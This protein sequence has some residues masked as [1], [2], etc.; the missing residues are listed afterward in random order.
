MNVR[1]A[2]PA[3]INLTLRVGPARADGLHPLQSVVAFA[4][5]GE[6]LEAA[7]ADVL[8]LTIIGPFAADLEADESNLVMRAARA[9][10]AAAGKP[11][12]GAA[13]TLFKDYPVASGIGGGSS[14]AAAALKAL[15][16][17]WGL[18]FS[19]AQL[20]EIARGLGSDT[21]ACVPARAAFM[22]G[23][24]A[25]FIPFDLPT[26]YAVLFNPRQPLP[27]AGVYRQFD[28]M[29]LGATFEAEA[30]APVWRD[31]ASAAAGMAVLG[32]DLYAPAAA[33][34]P[35]LNTALA[36]LRAD[37]R[38]LHAHM[39]GSGAT[40][41][42]LCESLEA[43]RGLEAAFAASNPSFWVRAGLLG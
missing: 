33:L 12:A 8:S 24:G 32:N 31:A 9:L 39:S 36:Q 16:R 4:A 37:P 2:A 10:A 41:F 18:N 5:C 28:L 34:M 30:P 14:D 7:P 40:M 23:T 13:L 22:F 27:T 43:A 6:W 20:I 17:L 42:A 38:T 1:V 29:A 21:P 15:N 25:D 26:L 19:E 35:D 11:E 3:K